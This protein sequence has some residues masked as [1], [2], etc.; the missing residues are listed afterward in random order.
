MMRWQRWLRAGGENNV[1]RLI[2]MASAVTLVGAGVAGL[3]AASS[4]GGHKQS[5]AAVNL[6]RKLWGQTPQTYQVDVHEGGGTISPAPLTTV[7]LT[8]DN[9]DPFAGD[10]VTLT[11]TTADDVSADGWALDIYDVTTGQWVGQPVTSGTTDTQTISLPDPG[12]HTYVAYVEDPDSTETPVAKSAQVVVTWRMK[13]DVSLDAV[14]T[15]VTG[16][17]VTISGT[18]TYRGQPVPN[19]TVALSVNP[20]TLSAQTVT[21]DSQGRFSVTYS[22]PT[23]PCTVTVTATDQTDGH[24][25]STSFSVVSPHIQSVSFDTSQWPPVVT[26]TGIGFGS[27]PGSVTWGDNTRGWGS[28]AVQA[29]IQSWSDTRVVF[30]F[31]TSYGSADAGLYNDGQGSWVF[32]PGDAITFTVTP[33]GGSALTANATYPSNARMPS[34]SLGAL[35]PVFVGQSTTVSGTVTFNGS[36]LAN[37]AVELKATA[38]SFSGGNGGTATGWGT[39]MVWTDSQGRFSAT[40]KA[41]QTGEN[42]TITASSAG[43]SQNGTLNVQQGATSVTLTA[44]PESSNPGDTSVRLTATANAPLAPNQTLEIVDQTTGQV[45]AG[46]ANQQTLTVTYTLPQGA[47]HQFV[48]ELNG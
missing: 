16:R 4:Y 40:Y 10:S 11:A 3:W 21:T 12:S 29:V 24:S 7:E 42:V 47:T 32:R 33:S 34:V 23:T 48:A 36:P 20:G 27:Q 30:T 8:A 35:N 2:W 41:P 17:Q 1:P 39:Y 26:I 43:A 38:G 14:P 19:E 9:T 28:G 31:N 46:P 6:T 15:V 5:V 37:V 13:P 45:I 18:V 25:A 22:A 44:T